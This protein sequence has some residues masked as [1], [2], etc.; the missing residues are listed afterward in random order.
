MIKPQNWDTTEPAKEFGDFENLELGGHIVVIK[1]AYEYTGTTGNTSLKIEVDIADG[2]QKDFFKKQFDANTNMDKKW[3]NGAVKYISLN[4]EHTS[5]FKGFITTIENSNPGYKWNFEEN[6]L[7]GK[8]LVG[9]FGLEEYTKQDGSIGLATKLTQFRSLDK[10]NEVQ[11]PKVKT[12]NNQYVDYN[13]YM[14]NRNN[15]SIEKTFGTDS[16]SLD[17]CDLD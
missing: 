12:L 15:N 6:T 2:K 10:L 4:E 7:I 16:V 8:R 5:L 3:P 9:V 14:S 13:E 17:D 11:I 1:N